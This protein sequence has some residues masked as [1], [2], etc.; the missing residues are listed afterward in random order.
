MDTIFFIDTFYTFRN[1]IL[2]GASVNNDLTP[3]FT[4]STQK[5]I[6]YNQGDRNEA[7]N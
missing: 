3:A 4:F 5:L 1:C 6:K 2:F 7:L